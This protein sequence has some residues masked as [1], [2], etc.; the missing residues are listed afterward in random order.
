MCLSD[1]QIGQIGQPRHQGGHIGHDLDKAL[2]TGI[3]KSLRDHMVDQAD[4]RLLVTCHIHQKDG[5]VMQP[6]LAPC[7]H[8]EE[9]VERPRPPGQHHDRVGIHE[10]DLFALMHR[11][12]DDECGLRQAINILLRPKLDESSALVSRR[13]FWA[14]IVV[15]T[16]RAGS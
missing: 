10:H 1:R 8:L 16:K 6:K 12:G 15:R 3:G 13:Q 2:Q 11:F 4:Q 7:Q 9:F 5:F 14:V